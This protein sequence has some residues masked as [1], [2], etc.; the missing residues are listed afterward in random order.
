MT[1]EER[2]AFEQFW[3]LVQ[4]N[5]EYVLQYANAPCPD[6]GERWDEEL[7]TAYER[8]KPILQPLAKNRFFSGPPGLIGQ[9][10]PFMAETAHQAL[11][12]LLNP[13]EVLFWHIEVLSG[14]EYL[15]IRKEAEEE[16]RQIQN[17]TV[18]GS[19]EKRGIPPEV[20]SQSVVQ[21]GDV[22]LNQSQK[23]ILAAVDS[24][25]RKAQDVATK[26]GYSYDL[27]RRH[28][29]T[30]KRLGLVKHNGDEYYRP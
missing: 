2:H 22:P 28:L 20:G 30:L 26:A 10:G 13:P 12:F 4:L 16:L 15:E 9:T 18:A 27:V 5:E 6:A 25:P 21:A 17:R 7:A 24:T 3:R 29:P 8:I 19:A 23:E 11:M 1:D 14:P